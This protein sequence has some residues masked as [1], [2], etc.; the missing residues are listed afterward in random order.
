MFKILFAKVGYVNTIE[1]LCN[2]V[3]IVRNDSKPITH[4][5]AFSLLL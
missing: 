3:E 1:K 4:L 2:Y 5:R